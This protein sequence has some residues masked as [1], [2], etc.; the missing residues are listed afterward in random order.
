MLQ[1]PIDK[2]S[3]RGLAALHYFW[4]LKLGTRT[5]DF[6]SNMPSADLIGLPF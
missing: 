3:E 2:R 4:S 6:R 5:F 1:V